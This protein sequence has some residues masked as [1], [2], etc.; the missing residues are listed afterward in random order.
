M[1]MQLLTV[2][3]ERAELRAALDRALIQRDIANEM[4]EALERALSSTGS[5]PSG[6]CEFG[7][8]G[9][10]VTVEAAAMRFERSRQTIRRWCRHEGAGRRVGGQ[11]RVDVERA[12]A[13]ANR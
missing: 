11:W 12:K 9:S 5:E 7:R 8:S 6:A 10:T 2:S 13:L 4:V 3:T 1:T